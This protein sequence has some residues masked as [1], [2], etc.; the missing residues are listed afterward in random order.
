MRRSALAGRCLRVV[1]LLTFVVEIKSLPWLRVT[2]ITQVLHCPF[3]NGVDIVRHG[4]T[5]QGKQR[6]R[7]RESLCE[8]R[9]FV[10]DY[11]YPGQSRLVKQQMIDMTLNGSGIRDTARVLHVSTNT[12]MNEL[13]KRT[14]SPASESSC[15]TATKSRASGGGYLS[16]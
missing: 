2:M 13:K 6:Y 4:R 14:G 5:P 10:L 12:V 16:G 8:G 9:T 11:T 15:V 7:C 3:C 1:D